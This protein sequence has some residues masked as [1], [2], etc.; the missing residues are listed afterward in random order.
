MAPALGRFG[1]IFDRMP[2]LNSLKIKALPS[3]LSKS[4]EARLW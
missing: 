3:V 2:I 1:A 4:I